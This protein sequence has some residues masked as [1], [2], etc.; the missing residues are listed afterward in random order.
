VSL[1]ALDMT[2]RLITSVV[3]FSDKLKKKIVP[4]L[5]KVD[6]MKGVYKMGTTSSIYRT[7]LQ[8]WDTV[9]SASTRLSDPATRH[10]PACTGKS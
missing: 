5:E 1:L 9:T 7:G 2:L 8:V 4:T 3:R 10:S 6:V